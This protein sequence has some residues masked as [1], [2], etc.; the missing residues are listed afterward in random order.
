MSSPSGGRGEGTVVYASRFLPLFEAF[1]FKVD[2]ID[3]TF[4]IILRLS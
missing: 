4:S 1:K 2:A 3:D